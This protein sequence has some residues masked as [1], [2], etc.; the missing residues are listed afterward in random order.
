M[1]R[2]E[3]VR[4]KV[5]PRQVGVGLKRRQET[6]KRSGRRLAWWGSTENEASHLLGLRE[7]TNTETSTPIETELLVW[8]PSQW[9]PRERRTKWP[10]RQRKENS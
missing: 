9:G 5:I 1:F 10:D 8:P 3:K 7:D 2:K 6:S 4:S